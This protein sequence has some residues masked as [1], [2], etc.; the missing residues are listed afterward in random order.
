MGHQQRRRLRE[1]GGATNYLAQTPPSVTPDG[2]VIAGGGPGSRLTAI[3]DTAE[4]GEEVWTQQD[5]SP[6][7]TSSLAEVGYAVVRDESDPEGLALLVFSLGDGSTLNTYRLPNASG[8]P[9]GVSIGHDRRVVA[10]T[11][12]GQ[13]YGFAPE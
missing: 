11:S 9:V 12:D 1:V 2:L 10:A 7:T 8:W 4:E 13:I 6:L 5:T 3:R